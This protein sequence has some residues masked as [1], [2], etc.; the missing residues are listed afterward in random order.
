MQP[1]PRPVGQSPDPISGVLHGL[2]RGPAGQVGDGL[3]PTTRRMA[4]QPVLKAEEVTAFPAHLQVH[5]PRLGLLWLQAKVG[6]QHPQPRKRGLGAPAPRARGRPMPGRAGAGR[7]CRARGMP[8]TLRGAGDRPADRS[9]L[10]HPSAQ[11]GAQQLQDALVADAF[12]DRLY[13]PGMPKSPRNSWR[14]PWQPPN[15]ARAMPRR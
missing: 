2:V 4:Y 5:D 9:V 15:A 12:G 6:Q 14:C 8:P 13:Q 3:A 7:R 11:H 10:H 1:Q